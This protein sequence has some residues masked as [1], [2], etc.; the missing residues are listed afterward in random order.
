MDVADRRHY[1]ARSAM[2][3]LLLLSALLSALTGV[4]AGGVRS[5]VAAEQVAQRAASAAAAVLAAPV[6]R[7]APRQRF[8]I[9]AARRAVAPLVRLPRFDLPAFASR[10]RE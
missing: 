2:N 1:I 9:A 8:D 3:V 7:H 6:V 4:N 5:P 10:R